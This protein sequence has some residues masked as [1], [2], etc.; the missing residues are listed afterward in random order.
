MT[1][2]KH[3]YLLL[4]LFGFYL[5]LDGVVSIWYFLPQEFF[6]HVP[7]VIRSL[8]GVYLIWMWYKHLD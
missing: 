8:I 2:E 5:I 7:R 6:K 3:F 1:V 4:A